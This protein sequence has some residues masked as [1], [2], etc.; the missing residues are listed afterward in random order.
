MSIIVVRTSAGLNNGN[1]G[2]VEM[3]EIDS[4]FEHRGWVRGKTDDGC[5]WFN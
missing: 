1:L 2:I 4:M 5:T 3:Y